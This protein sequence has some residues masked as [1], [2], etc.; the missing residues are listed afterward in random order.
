M[1]KIRRTEITVE[2]ERVLIISW[3][4]RVFD[5]WCERCGRETHKVTAEDA[6]RATRVGLRALCSLVE[7]HHVH[8]VETDGALYICA[9]SLMNYARDS[10]GFNEPE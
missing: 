5:S 6:A 3:S 1:R 2:T 4:R 9:D 8:F 7:A 10:L